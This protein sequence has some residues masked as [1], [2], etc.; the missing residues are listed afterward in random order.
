MNLLILFGIRGICLRSGSS[1]S[2]YLLILRVIK[3]T[4]VVN[5]AI[6]VLSTTYRIL[7]NILLSRLSSYAEEIFRDHQCGFRRKRSTAGLVV[8]IR[9]ILE[10]KWEFIESVHQLLIK[11]EK[12]Y[13]SISKYV[14]LSLISPR[15]WLG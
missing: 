6:L 14:S 12:A 5:R 8:C 1:R 2:L 7:S 11:V 9:K 13:D 3:R 15:N 4:V 10:K